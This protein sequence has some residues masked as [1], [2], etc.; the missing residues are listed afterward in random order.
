MT[1]ST[2]ITER[3]RSPW[4]ARLYGCLVF[5]PAL[6]I[7]W[8]VVFD[9][10][11]IP[12]WEDGLFLEP[13]R[14]AM[15]VLVRAVLEGVRIH[16]P[17]HTP[18]LKILERHEWTFSF[19]GRIGIAVV[20]AYTAAIPIAG[21]RFQQT[22]RRLQTKWVGRNIPPWSEGSDAIGN[23]NA[24]LAD[25]IGRTG[26]GLEICPGITLSKEQEARSILAV[27][28][29]G[30]GKTVAFWQVIFQLLM[31]NVFIIGHDVKGDWTARWPKKIILM[32]P[33]DVRSWGW[34]IGQDIVGTVLARELST[35]LVAAAERDPNWAEGAREILVGI[36]T[37]LQREKGTE[38]GWCELKVALD[39]DDAALQEF[40]CR[41]HPLAKRFLALDE[42]QNFTKNAG[43]YVGTLMAPIN[44]LIGPLAAAW[45]DLEPR[46]QL[47]LTAW[48]DDPNPQSRT[49]ILQR[50]PDLGALS[51]AWI[52]S[53]VQMIARHLVSTRRDRNPGDIKTAQSPP[54]VWFLLDEFASLGPISSELLPLL[55]VG[56]SLGL[57]AMI[58]LQ[59]FQ[60]LSRIQNPQA[61]A[62]FLQL[63]GNL[64]CFRLNPGADAKRICEERLTTA[65]VRT[66]VQ[67]NQTKIKEPASEDIRILNQEDLAR[68]RITRDGAEGYLIIGNAAFGLEW[69]FPETPVQRDGSV[70]AAWI[71]R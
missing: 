65:P 53:A 41:Y 37:T 31:R 48:L 29:P 58:G 19:F 27:G 18:V 10:V 20:A 8:V 62:E 38:W 3:H 66:W 7:G 28:E 49:L 4:K 55:E 34:A 15:T 23:A 16:S 52:G 2:K 36:I 14:D 45:G 46:F 64:I 47:S 54:D 12:G 70:R 25:G 1:A 22:P 33:H 40:A 59:N 43:S 26:R 67:N 11:R 30:S 51:T 42:T 71:R 35:L 32:A 50:A 17:D 24:T 5:I 63:I 61:P 57:R 21:W 56:R 60:Q 39:M 13:S 68:L 44:K 9:I 6:A 69:P